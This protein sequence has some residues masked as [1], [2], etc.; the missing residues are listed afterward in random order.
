MVAWIYC[1]HLIKKLIYIKIAIHFYI[2]AFKF[3]TSFPKHLL[4][5]NLHDDITG[6]SA[7]FAALTLRIRLAPRTPTKPT[8]A[9]NDP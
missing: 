2:T 4:L 3:N 6:F 7:S 1:H 8:W 5:G 9:V